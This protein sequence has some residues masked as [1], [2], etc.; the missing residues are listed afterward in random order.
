[1]GQD[2]VIENRRNRPGYPVVVMKPDAENRCGKQNEHHG[3][4]ATPPEA[5]VQNF[6]NAW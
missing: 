4:L 1:M 2:T 3:D 6:S 5:R